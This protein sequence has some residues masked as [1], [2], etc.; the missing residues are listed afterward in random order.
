MKVKIF[1]AVTLTAVIVLVTLN[2]VAL[3]RIVDGTIREI[4]A[5]DPYEDGAEGKARDIYERFGRLEVFVSITVSHDDLTNIES[6][7]SEMIGCLSVG[8]KDDAEVVKNRLRDSLVHLRR[9]VGIN[10]DSII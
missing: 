2:T 6:C 5:F 4:D 7:F 9:L 8:M 1:A 10:P 3:E